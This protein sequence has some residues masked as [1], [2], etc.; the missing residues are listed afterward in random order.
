MFSKSSSNSAFFVK[1]VPI[2]DSK[3]ISASAS[4]IE[5]ISD[6]LKVSSQASRKR[7]S[8]EKEQLKTAAKK[9]K[10]YSQNESKDFRLFSATKQQVDPLIDLCLQMIDL[11]EKSNTCR[12]K[13]NH[14][15]II[16]LQEL[17]FLQS[18]L[19]H[20]FQKVLSPLPESQKMTIE[21]L[22]GLIT[23]T[24]AHNSILEMLELS[25][26][27]ISAQQ[28]AVDEGTDQIKKLYCLR[29]EKDEKSVSS[30]TPLINKF[31]NLMKDLLFNQLVRN[32]TTI[33]ERQK[34][35][36]MQIQ[37]LHDLKEEPY[38]LIT[39]L[40]QEDMQELTSESTQEEILKA[41]KLSN[42]II[43]NQDTDIDHNLVKIDNLVERKLKA[44]K[45]RQLSSNLVRPHSRKSF[46]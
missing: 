45:E 17:T 10:S 28:K 43:K 19:L 3:L 2:Q 4:A 20:N 7:R 16:E 1:N 34:I 37:L 13:R 11:N 8:S 21:G 23:E 33:A 36:Q 39:T 6:P 31:V 24:T 38:R 25:N 27:V 18:L 42:E 41:L 22:N 9:Q 32:L 40:A 14:E 15:M 5:S 26:T 12:L 29:D 30:I 44:F 35:I 46:R